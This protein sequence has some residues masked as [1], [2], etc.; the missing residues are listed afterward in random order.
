MALLLGF[1]TMAGIGGG[2]AISPILMV[3]F[4]FTLKEAVPISSMAIMFGGL[5]RFLMNF[6]EKHPL[7]DAVSIDYGLAAVMMP[8]VIIGTVIGAYLYILLPSVVILIIV[9]LLFIGLSI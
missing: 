8:S 9:T 6:N 7:K 3:C 1:A 2:G 4:G 5:N